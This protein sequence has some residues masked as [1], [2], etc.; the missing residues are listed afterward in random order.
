MSFNTGDWCTNNQ[1]LRHVFIVF[2]VG[3]Q[4]SEWYPVQ[5][6]ALTITAPGCNVC[7]KSTTAVGE[8]SEERENFEGA[9]VEE[10]LIRFGN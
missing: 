1:S 4:H 10:I 6:V 3:A 2:L 7:V 9:T 8:S 5:R